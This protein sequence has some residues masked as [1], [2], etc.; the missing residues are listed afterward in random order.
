MRAPAL[1]ALL[2]LVFIVLTSSVVYGELQ[3]HTPGFP[4]AQSSSLNGLL[5]LL[6]EI[7][8]GNLSEVPLNS[9]V[10]SINDSS[11]RGLAES[12]VE[13]YE[14][15]KLSSTD[16]LKALAEL[17]SW[18][19]SRG[20]DPEALRDYMLVLELL[21]R[22]AEMQ[23][24][25]DISEYIKNIQV[26]EYERFISYLKYLQSGTEG[27]TFMPKH[28][29][30]PPELNSSA[31]QGIGKLPALGNF[32]LPQLPAG[33]P[34]PGL[35]QVPALQVSSEYLQPVLYAIAVAL[36]VA[37][38]VILAPRAK[39]ALG[40]AVQAARFRLLGTPPLAEEP[41][42]PLPK[43]IAVYWRAVDYLSSMYSVKKQP[44]QTH[45]EFLGVIEKHAVEKHARLF[46]EITKLYELVRYAN[47]T[48]EKLGEEAERAL[49][50]MVSS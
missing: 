5:E 42:T 29:P 43:A 10:S 33:P 25:R 41:R 36:A 38:V 21:R 28:L 37:A 45:R 18:Y 48:D 17:S 11:V 7:L 26:S 20:G 19:S 44:W 47:I 31:L 27:Y 2:A 15:G 50:E 35:P 16:L 12:L 22:I 34:L 13:N 49:V 30:E 46:N 14:A 6:R 1:L 24:Y 8:G 3:R 40:R 4:E 9:L 32:S 23:G 39:K